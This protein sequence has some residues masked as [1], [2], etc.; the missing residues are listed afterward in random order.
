MSE[1]RAHD[2]LHT[3][4]VR[5]MRAQALLDALAVRVVIA[6]GAMGTMLQEHNPTLEDYQQLEGATRSSMS[7]GPT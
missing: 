5:P 7:A 1:P 3:D 2:A 6:D 4:A